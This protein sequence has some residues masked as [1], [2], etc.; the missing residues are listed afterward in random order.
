MRKLQVPGVAFGIYYQGE[1]HTAGFGVTNIDNPLPVTPQTLFPIGSISKTFT[2]LLAMR[3]VEEGKLDLDKPIKHYSPHFRMRD[4]NTKNHLT[5][6]HLLTHTGGWTGDYF[7]QQGEGD[8]ALAKVVD[9]ISRLPQHFPLGEFFSYNNS[10]FYLAGFVLQEIAKKPFE[11]LMQEWVFDPIEMKE[12]YYFV[13]DFCSKRFTIG[14][15]HLPDSPPAVVPLYGC[16]RMANPAGGIVTN[17]E[18]LLR[19][20]RIYLNKGKNDHGKKI[21][22]TT[23]IHA[24]QTPQVPIYENK[25]DWQTMGLG[26][27][28]N[29]IDG[30][31]I[32]SHTGGV[33]AQATLLTVIPEHDFACVIATNSGVGA[34]LFL[35]LAP[36][37]YWQYVGIHPNLPKPQTTSDGTLK[38]YLGTYLGAAG[39]KIIIDQ[40]GKKLTLRF[41]HSAQVIKELK[42]PEKYAIN[43]PPIEIALVNELTWIAL[44][45]DIP[46]MRGEFMKDRAGNIAWMRAGRALKK[47]AL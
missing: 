10:G 26:W 27:F 14:H 18:E 1:M 15:E 47:I 9:E 19:Y 42:V 36:Q 44:S 20:A 29:E 28:C 22:S 39:E 25:T 8:D 12:V 31:K 41:I 21:I 6:R 23:S 40:I 16:G 38:S 32:Y 2:T 7:Q 45:N 3:F 5:M 4:P 34:K 11:T 13:N 17:I 43:P 37:I 35:G 24:M 30:V 46:G 33:H